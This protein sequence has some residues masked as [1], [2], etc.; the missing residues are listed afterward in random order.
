VG[1]NRHGPGARSQRLAKTGDHAVHGKVRTISAPVWGRGELLYYR[2]I[3]KKGMAIYVVDQGD[4]RRIL[5]TGDRIGGKR[6][7]DFNLGWHP[8]QVDRKGRLAFQ[9]QYANG[10]TGIV[11]GTPA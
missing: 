4:R 6:V 5:D 8:D 10:R 2:T 11:I 9:V 3:S 1:L 7:K